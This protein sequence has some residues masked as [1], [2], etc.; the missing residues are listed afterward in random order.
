MGLFSSWFKK[1]TDSKEQAPALEPEA[2][3]E[4]VEELAGA[5]AGADGAARVDAARVLLDRWRAGDG[6]AAGAIVARVEDL[7]E[8]PEPQVRIAAL[9][10]VAAALLVESD[11]AVPEVETVDQPVAV[12]LAA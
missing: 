10:A 9:G 5:L 3:Q 1:G 12:E 11:P 2:A 6:E 4:T 8:D 7:L